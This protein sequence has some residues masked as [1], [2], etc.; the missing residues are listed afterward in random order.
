MKNAIN[1]REEENMERINQELRSQ[2][3][4]KAY[5]LLKIQESDLQRVYDLDQD[6]TDQD[7]TDWVKEHLI[8]HSN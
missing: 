4:D 1:Q 2:T 8:Y 6:L 7:I 5:Q 3:S